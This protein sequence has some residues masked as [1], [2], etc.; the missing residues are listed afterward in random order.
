VSAAI[1]EATAELTQRMLHLR[2]VPVG[3]M[4]SPSVVR[5]LASNLEPRAF[6]KGEVV[7]RHGDPVDALYLLTEG[8]LDLL[9]DGKKIGELKA[10]QTL[11]FLGILARQESPYDAVAQGEVLALE[12]ETDALL[13]VMEDHFEFLAVTLKYL[14]ERLFYEFQELPESA[15]GIAPMDLGPVDPE[16]IHLVDR[17][18]LMRRMTGFA[19]ANVNALAAMARQMEEARFPAGTTLWSAGDR[20]D[21]VIFLVSGTLECTTP[22]GRTF[23][24]GAG[25][26]AGG[27]EVIAERPRWYDCVTETPIVGL[28]GVPEDMLDL[29]EHQFRMAMDFLAMLARAQIAFIERKA[30]LGQNPLSAL[31]DVTKLGAV[32][33]GG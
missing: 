27:I 6:A 26:G 10:P 29:F 11:G 3:A 31:R 12:L 4:L 1:R 7:M 13:E 33:V 14:A 23:R 28:W 21:R 20:A 8:G 9:R 24:Y 19:T 18:L 17:V 22:D 2:Q 5:V 15:L 32:R 16:R 30:K 25:T